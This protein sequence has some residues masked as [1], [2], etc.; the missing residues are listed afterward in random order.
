MKEFSRLAKLAK[1]LNRREIWA[2][3][4]EIAAIID[5]D[6]ELSAGQKPEAYD[7]ASSEFEDYDNSTIGANVFAGAAIDTV[8]DKRYSDLET[9]L[10]ELFMEKLSEELS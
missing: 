1:E 4:L 10:H 3:R 5:G 2:Y 8:L 9:D 7:I 6:N